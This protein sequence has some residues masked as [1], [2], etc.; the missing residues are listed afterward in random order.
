MIPAID[1]QKVS[2]VNIGSIAVTGESLHVVIDLQAD[3][4]VFLPYK[5]GI[6]LQPLYKE[7][8]PQLSYR[9][10]RLRTWNRSPKYPLE[11]L[12]VSA[13]GSKP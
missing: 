1:R 2:T 7:G 6:R 5:E 10:R 12:L 13:V 4:G 11:S 8:S 3:A 9:P